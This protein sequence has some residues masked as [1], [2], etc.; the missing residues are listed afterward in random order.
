ME[1]LLI[2]SLSINK[3]EPSKKLNPQWFSKTDLQK[4]KQDLKLSKSLKNFWTPTEIQCFFNEFSG[5]REILEMF[6]LF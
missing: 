1:H 4:L 2:V 5:I 3:F 6:C